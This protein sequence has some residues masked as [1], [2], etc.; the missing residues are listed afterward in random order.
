MHLE[1]LHHRRHLDA[2][3]QGHAPHRLARGVCVRDRSSS[4]PGTAAAST[5]RLR[6]STARSAR[7]PGR[8]GP[9]VLCN[10][11]VPQ[12]L[13]VH[14]VV[15]SS[16]PAL[17]VISIL[18]NVGMWFERFVIIVIVA[19]PAAILPVELGHVLS[20][21]HRSRDAGRRASA[22]SSRC[23]CSSSALLPMIAMWGDQGQAWA[24]PARVSGQRMSSAHRSPT[25]AGAER[26]CSRR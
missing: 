22:S 1:R 20:D 13:W 9:M 25:F 3:A 7:T 11:L 16:V 2:M 5:S 19:A 8:S 4:P 6:S 15:R 26:A 17:F 18:V 14:A 24:P 23:S 21:V 12:L 10:V